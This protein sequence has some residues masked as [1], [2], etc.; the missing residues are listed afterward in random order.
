MS[1]EKIEIIITGG[2]IDSYY[3]GVHDTVKPSEE[4]IIPEF[5]K[6]LKAYDEFIFNTVCM[7][8]S[9]NLTENDRLYI[10]DAIEKSE[11]KR[12]IVTHGTYTMPDTS[13]YLKANL[14]RKDQ[15]IIFTGSMIPIKG[16]APSDGGF[17]LGFAISESN[18]LKPGTYTC[19]N[20]R[21]FDPDEIIK[22]LSEGRFG[23]IYNK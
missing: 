12:I 7:K 3:D 17:N 10:K 9:R 8:D 16:F 4:S 14:K 2:T 15:V 21:I 18:H 5:I 23:S 11:S 20:A 6:S 13:K 19:M 22:L 1:K